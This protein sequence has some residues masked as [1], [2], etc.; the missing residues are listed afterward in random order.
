MRG[1]HCVRPTG[2]VVRR[3]RPSP[4]TPPDR[5][6]VQFKTAGDLRNRGPLAKRQP[7]NL[8][9]PLL[10]DYRHSWDGMTSG[11]IVAASTSIS[12]DISLPRVKGGGGEFSVPVSGDYWVPDD[13]KG[14]GIRAVA[15]KVGVGV[16]TVQRVKAEQAA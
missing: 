13:T 8:L 3:P 7:A 5:L 6:A 11:P 9:P 4:Q 16:G 2:P 10:T 15:R 12:I 1:Q 14:T